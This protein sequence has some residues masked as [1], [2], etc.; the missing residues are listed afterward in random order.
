M[1]S[2]SETWG[3]TPDERRRPFPCDDV[4]SQPDAVVYRGLTINA[5]PETVFR[6]LCQLRLCCLEAAIAHAV[7]H[8]EIMATINKMKR[9]ILVL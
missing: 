5:P 9:P 7:S 3:T 6:W 8:D 2:I 4:I 1:S